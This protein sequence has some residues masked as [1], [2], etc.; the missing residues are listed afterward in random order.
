MDGIEHWKEVAAT[1]EANEKETYTYLFSEDLD[2]E[3]RLCS[4]ERY[5]SQSF[6]KEVHI[7]S[8]AIQQNMAKQ[9]DIRTG[10]RLHFMTQLYMRVLKG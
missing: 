8:K 5:S 7:P 9:K 10:L 6:L 3:Q 1:V 4:V 2:D